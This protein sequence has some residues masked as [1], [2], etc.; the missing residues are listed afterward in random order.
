MAQ[1]WGVGSQQ[2]AVSVLE[3]KLLRF[4]HSGERKAITSLGLM[5]LQPEMLTSPAG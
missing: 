1:G 5:L 2:K 3:Q 4:T